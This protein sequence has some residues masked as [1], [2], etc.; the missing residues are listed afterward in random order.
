MTSRVARLLLGPWLALVA[1]DAGVS[2]PRV[3]EVY[4]ASSLIDAFADVERELEAAEPGL[5]VVVSTAGSQILRMQIEHGGPADVFASADPDHVQAL[6]DGGWL[7]DGEAFADNGLA[8]IVPRPGPG[9][10]R[11]FEDLP[12]A[13]R[14]VIGAPNVPVGRY[15]RQMLR[16]AGEA[17]RGRFEALTM[18]RVVSEETNARLVRAKVE[19]GEADA[20]IVYRSDAIASDRV[21]LVEVPEEHDVR[22]EYRAGVVAGTAEPEL[23][24]R[25]VALLRS[26]RGQAILARHGFGPPP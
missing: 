4:A 1:C 24:S 20:A 23:A 3:L 12:R 21:T 18:S 8:V 7:V 2:E 15:A 17:S 25:F 26:P 16:R 10:V 19:L 14:L 9:R 13:E 5:D 11:S 6:L 22:A